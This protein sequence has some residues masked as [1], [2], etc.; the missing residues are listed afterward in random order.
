MGSRLDGLAE[1]IVD[2]SESVS[3]VR[4]K[5]G[6]NI[7]DPGILMAVKMAGKRCFKPRREGF[8]DASGGGARRLTGR[9]D[10]GVHRERRVPLKESKTS[11]A[12]NRDADLEF[13]VAKEVSDKVALELVLANRS[14]LTFRV[15]S[16]GHKVP[17]VLKQVL[18]RLKAIDGGFDVLRRQLGKGGEGGRASRWPE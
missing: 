3:L 16:I 2:R 12:S 5:Q 4:Q 8:L 13:A 6:T 17:D 7:V 9:G 10:G 1:R 18:G 11:S 14:R 15:K